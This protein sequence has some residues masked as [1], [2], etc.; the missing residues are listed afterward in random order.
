MRDS[1]RWGIL[2]TGQIAQQFTKD[3][4]LA[5]MDVAAVGSRSLDSAQRF[6]EE[7]AIPRAHGSYQELVNDETVDIIYVA[8]PHPWHFENAMMAL[9][10]GKHVLV[11]KPFTLNKPQAEVLRDTA[12]SRELLVTEAMWTRYLP[13]M[14][15]IREIIA[16][17]GLGEVRTVFA[18]HTQRASEDPTHRLNA[19][20]LG[21]G[22][23]LDLGVYPVS[24]IWDM[25]GA[26]STVQAAGQL[27]STGADTEIA[28]VMTHSSGAIST[29][30]V[31]SRAKG[32]NTAHIVGTEGRIDIHPTWYAASGFTHYNTAGEIIEQYTV[33]S[34]GNGM[35]YQA[36]AVEQYLSE[37]ILEGDLITINESVEIMGTLDEIR[38]QVGV[39]YPTEDS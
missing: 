35:Q 23:L 13:H 38:S 19:L 10:A 11:E 7:F 17:G 3:A 5:R 9:E 21:G 6:A 14:V 28:V 15:R 4:Q 39:R 36:I 37:G 26:P 2:A 20:E 16:S 29:C 1:L 12:R 18:D 32:P 33:P 25:L 31:S 24:F 22:A 30:T 34:E 8:T 27:G